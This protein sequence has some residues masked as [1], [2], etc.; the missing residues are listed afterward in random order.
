M[1]TDDVEFQPVGQTEEGYYLDGSPASVPSALER[2]SI[3]Q[4]V[5]QAAS[6]L[7][8]FNW[9]KKEPSRRPPPYSRPPPRRAPPPNRPAILIPRHAPAEPPEQPNKRRKVYEIEFGK[10]IKREEYGENPPT[11]GAMPPNVDLMVDER[12]PKSPT[13]SVGSYLTEDE[14][15]DLE[16]LSSSSSSIV[17]RRK[18][19]SEGSRTSGSSR[20]IFDSDRK[21]SSSGLPRFPLSERRDL[22][23]PLSSASSRQTTGLPSVLTP[24]RSSQVSTN[25]QH[26]PLMSEV[27]SPVSS[28][29]S[30]TPPQAT[31]NKKRN[32][33]EVDKDE[34][35]PSFFST[36]P[37]SADR[38]SSGVLPVSR[39]GSRVSEVQA[40]SSGNSGPLATNLSKRYLGNSGVKIPLNTQSDSAR[41]SPASSELEKMFPPLKRMP[42]PG[43][44]S[45]P[46]QSADKSANRN[47]LK[48][49]N[50]DYKYVVRSPVVLPTDGQDFVF[51]A[52]IVVPS[53]ALAQ[54]I[55]I[56]GFSTEPSPRHSPPP[57]IHRCR[58]C[59]ISVKSGEQ[60]CSECTGARAT[61]QDTVRI[62]HMESKKKETTVVETGG[63]TCKNCGNH[64]SERTERCVECGAK[65]PAG[66]AIEKPSST[67]KPSTSSE[68]VESV[69]VP[70][71]T[72]KE[73]VPRTGQPETAS[74]AP[75]EVEKTTEFS[76]KDASATT[77]AA[78]ST[79]VDI[80]SKKKSGWDCQE[81]FVS[82]KDGQNACASCGTP[83]PG[84]ASTSS[85]AS[86]AAAAPAPS[87]SFGSGAMNFQF[88]APLAK[89]TEPSAPASTAAPVTT[90]GFSFGSKPSASTNEPA[91][92]TGIFGAPITTSLPSFNFGQPPVSGTSTAPPIAGFGFAP[93]A[94]IANGLPVSAPSKVDFTPVITST[95]ST[96]DAPRP[97]STGSVFGGFSLG[98][99]AAPSEP[100]KPAF[101]FGLNAPSQSSGSSLFGGLANGLS[102]SASTAPTSGLPT[103]GA[104]GQVKAAVT[105]APGNPAPFMFGQSNPAAASTFP[106]F[107]AQ[108]PSTTGFGAAPGGFSSS[109]ATTSGN[110]GVTFGSNLFGQSKSEAPPSGSLFNFGQPL[111]NGQTSTLPSSQ[112]IA[113]GISSQ[114]NAQ[115]L[116]ILGSQQ[117]AMPGQ[118]GT[119][120]SMGGP[121]NA[122]RILKA[123]RNITQR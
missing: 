41:S 81:C 12:P 114:P 112:S 90:G 79:F 35:L 33:Q 31:L 1:E 57:K 13:S 54:T 69:K 55:D 118:P 26:H 111:Q 28:A 68:S 84:A 17:N 107:T 77:T 15:S 14:D 10:I 18:K 64:Y 11:N 102:T 56:S 38:R 66:K 74:R 5:A 78:P 61:P 87:F 72:S 101:Q 123:K 105:A 94:P 93:A 36:F 117:P 37:R 122:R 49:E 75:L 98:T 22:S 51:N 96:F 92:S 95:S 47:R 88:G 62:E 34:A 48:L 60:E 119:F 59:G 108:I 73:T 103:F 99:A 58:L 97:S 9:F 110:S 45:S 83:R 71:S 50:L 104:E 106:G 8:P 30:A 120:G 53:G 67:V 29:T 70:A 46:L 24:S 6:L 52:S 115:V 65:K 7:N 80:W 76:S 116:S 16:V 27:Q 4:S 2:P 43:R 44:S 20:D 3:G 91:V 39:F 86:S 121:P 25:V 89:P 113:G 63:W 82:N 85:A 42:M 100:A 32:F 19:L 23:S 40:G 21:P 109:V